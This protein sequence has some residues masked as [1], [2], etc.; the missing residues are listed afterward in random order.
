MSIVLTSG[1]VKGGDIVM[2]AVNRGVLLG[3]ENG[4][5]KALEQ[6]SPTVAQ[7]TGKM[8]RAVEFATRQVLTQ[9]L[10]QEAQRI[11]IS[12]SQIRQIL[13]SIVAYSQFHWTDGPFGSSYKEPFTPGTKPMN[14]FDLKKIAVP[15]I[16]SEIDIVIRNEGP[17]A[18]VV[19]RGFKLASDT[20]QIGGQTV[21][22]VP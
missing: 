18:N 12:G 7:R 19:G 22:I 11:V 16:R 1:N 4:V 14:L 6:W 5:I 13:E 10:N 2:S 8:K 15:L 3:I 21:G 9:A 20:V 17:E